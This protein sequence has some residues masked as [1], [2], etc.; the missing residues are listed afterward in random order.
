MIPQQV[1]DS[2]AEQLKVVKEF[3][4]CLNVLALM[5]TLK[6]EQLSTTNSLIAGAPNGVQTFLLRE[7]LIGEARVR[8]AIIEALENLEYEL[9]NQL[10]DENEN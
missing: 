7:Q 6:D 4:K 10:K 2:S 3:F 8:Q 1:I 9:E 5:Q